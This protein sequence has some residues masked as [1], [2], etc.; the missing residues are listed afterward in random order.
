LRSRRHSRNEPDTS[1]AA[2]AGAHVALVALAMPIY[3]LYDK[4]LHPYQNLPP[5][6]TCVVWHC[7]FHMDQLMNMGNYHVRDIDGIVKRS[8][9]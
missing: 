5:V 3:L 2:F 6:L 7:R 9:L 8:E 1:K 4:V